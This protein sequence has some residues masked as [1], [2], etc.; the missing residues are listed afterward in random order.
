MQKELPAMPIE[1]IPHVIEPIPAPQGET[2]VGPTFSGFR[3]K[4]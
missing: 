2:K 4:L 1:F 3:D